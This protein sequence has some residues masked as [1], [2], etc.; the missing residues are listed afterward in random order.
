MRLNF[1]C[2][3]LVSLAAGSAHYRL[4]YIYDFPDIVVHPWP[5]RGIPLEGRSVWKHHFNENEGFGH[6]YNGTEYF[7]TWQY[8]SFQLI[9]SRLLRSKYR[10][11]DPD[12]AS[13]F[14]I[15]YDSGADAYAS[16]SGQYRVHG[17][18]ALSGWVL[19]HLSLL[20]RLKR[21]SGF[22]HF[23]VHSSSL[24]AHIVTQPVKKLLEICGNATILTVEKFPALPK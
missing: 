4:F 1:I 20:P 2:T 9:L 6:H 5:A 18:P 22:D 10:T 7:E 24:T 13:M 19:E 15:P 3:L 8:S 16:Q 11:R 17:I 23:Y 21:F 14:F 12:E